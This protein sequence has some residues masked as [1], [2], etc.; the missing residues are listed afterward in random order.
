MWV[1][2]TLVYPT[3]GYQILMD[4]SSSS[5][6]DHVIVGL[7]G[8]TLLPYLAVYEGGGYQA[9]QG[10]SAL[11]LGAWNHL[12]VSY[13]SG[14]G[15]A[16]IYV[17]GA[18]DSAA[19]SIWSPNSVTRQVNWIGSN[20]AEGS[21]PMPGS[22]MLLSIALPCHPARSVPTMPLGNREAAIRPRLLRLLRWDIGR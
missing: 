7:N 8:S 6:C 13:S 22:A 21:R 17:N 19:Q 14:S 5:F 12:V 9:V 20:N 10:S 4:F 3:V 11:T 15:N 1:H 2:P 18:P 16:T